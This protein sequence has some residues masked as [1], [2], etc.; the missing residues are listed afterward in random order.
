MF[1]NNENCENTGDKIDIL[2]NGNLIKSFDYTKINRLN[3]Y[4]QQESIRFDSETKVNQVKE[5]NYEL[6]KTNNY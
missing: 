3:R 5:T 1:C 4:W 6:F 2:I